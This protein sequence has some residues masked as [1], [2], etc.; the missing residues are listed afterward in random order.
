MSESSM[1]KEE[2]KREV[3]TF[4]EFLFPGSVIPEKEVRQVENRDIPEVPE[5]A[6]VYSFFDLNRTVV[7]KEEFWGSRNN[8]SGKVYPNAQILTVQDVK[9]QIPNS[10]ILV[11][12]MEGNGWDRVVRTRRGNF[13]PFNE[14]D[15]V[16]P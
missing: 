4:V 16:T 15:S 1:S 8:H 2:V 5:G 13:Q 6:F 14:G 3:V 7:G 10:D 12:N 11:A 9:D